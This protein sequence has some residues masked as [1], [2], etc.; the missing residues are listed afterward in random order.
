MLII[1]MRINANNKIWYTPYFSTLFR[2]SKSADCC[3]PLEYSRSTLLALLGV[4]ESLW[5]RLIGRI[6][7]VAPFLVGVL[8]L[9]DTSVKKIVVIKKKFI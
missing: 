4:V 1:A 5:R 3:C 2:L 9:A 6:E 7:V 8:C